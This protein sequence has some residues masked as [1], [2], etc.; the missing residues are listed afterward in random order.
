MATLA[1][2]DPAP[3]PAR[4]GPT[5]SLRS[6]QL[7][8]VL[9]SVAWHG[10]LVF[11]C[12]VVLV[13]IVMVILGSFK[14]VNEFFSTPYALPEAFDLANYRKAWDEANLQVALRNSVIVTVVGVAVST[15]LACL[16]SYGLARFRFPGGLTLRMLFVGG[17]VVPVQLIVLPIFIL[18]RQAGIL[19][20]LRSLILVYSVFGIPLGVLVLTGFLAVLPRDLEEAARIDGASHFEIF[21]RIMLPL[22]RPAIA[23]VVILNGVWMWNDFFLGFILLTDP[24]SQTL[25]V[26]IMAFRGTYSTEWGLIFAGVTVS[27]LPVIAAYLLLS[28]Q[29]IA[30]L[31]AGSVKG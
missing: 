1:P 2:T 23:A 19:G 11:V 17:L 3:F 22:S 27:A 25:P 28:R 14:S 26:A 18:F 30:G 15:A 31:T 9:G 24:Q 4:S 13:P 5:G 10:I 20:D 7:R 6:K 16:A 21:W 29:F 12:A 8:R